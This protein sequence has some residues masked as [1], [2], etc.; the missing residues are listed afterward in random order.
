MTGGPHRALGDLVRQAQREFLEMPG[1]RLTPAQARRLWGLDIPTCHTL[2][3]VLVDTRFL[4]CSFDGQY[5]RAEH[6]SP[7]GPD[8][9]VF[10]ATNAR[11]AEQEP[12]EPEAVFHH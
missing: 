10:D 9:E 12:T 4:A 7:V 8:A 2:L 1:L 5:Q 6:E 11:S 3:R